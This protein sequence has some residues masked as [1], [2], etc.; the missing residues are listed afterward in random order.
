[1]NLR[2]LVQQ[3]KDIKLNLQPLTLTIITNKFDIFL[4]LMI[5]LR[6]RIFISHKV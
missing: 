2:I 6:S 4:H 3:T 1:M 5:Y